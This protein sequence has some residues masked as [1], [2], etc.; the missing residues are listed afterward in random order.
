ME[1][2][3]LERSEDKLEIKVRDADDTVM[4]PLIEQLI[5]DERVTD[6]TYSVE[7]QE[8]DDPVLKMEVEEGEDPKEILIE[9]AKNF[10]QIFEDIY[11]DMFGEEEE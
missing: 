6:A 7:H 2:K 5:Q 9:I 3:V 11:E 8:L 4:Y 1:F 10:K